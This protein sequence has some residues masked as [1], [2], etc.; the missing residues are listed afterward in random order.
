MSLSQTETDGTVTL[1][2]A[3]ALVVDDEPLA[4]AHLAF[5]LREAGV[6]AVDEAQDGPQCLSRCRQRDR[7]PDWVFLDVRMPGL[8]GMAVA[9]ALRAGGADPPPAL[10]F[11]TGYEDFAVQ[12]FERAAVDYLL[13]PVARARLAATLERLAGR[14]APP[15]PALPALQRLPVRTDYAVRLLEVGQIVAA[16]ARERRVEIITE[17]VVYPTYYTLAEL[18]R[19]LPPAQFLRVHDGWIVNLARVVEVHNLGG[20]TYETT[21]RGTAQRAP[22]SRR[23]LR[24]LQEALGF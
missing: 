17:D 13:K 16:A 6:G 1:A 15:A 4:R 7:R 21:L 12:A 9:D 19:R 14:P 3:R 8:D 23:R 24:G 10:V 11:V 5:L 18:E 22:V 20:Q 2:H